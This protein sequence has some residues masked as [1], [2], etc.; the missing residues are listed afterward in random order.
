[1]L[2]MGLQ[3]LIIGGSDPRK[4]VVK[5]FPM[6][7]S[8]Q[9]HQFELLS[10]N[11]NSFTRAK[12]SRSEIIAPEWSIDK[13]RCFEECG[14]DSFELPCHLSPKPGQPSMQRDTLPKG[15]GE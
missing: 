1:M 2:K 12:D 14:K 15:G 10:M 11:K 4:M 6:L 9:K 3:E 7:L 5:Q 13:K 8:S